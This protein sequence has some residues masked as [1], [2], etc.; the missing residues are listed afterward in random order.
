MSKLLSRSLSLRS[1]SSSKRLNQKAEQAATSTATTAARVLRDIEFTTT[2]N[3]STLANSL[4][5]TSQE[6]HDRPQTSDGVTERSMDYSYYGPYDLT[7]CEPDAFGCPAPS[8]KSILYTAE[9][10][11]DPTIGVALGSPSQAPTWFQPMGDSGR[12]LEE[13]DPYLAPA[14]HTAAH[15]NSRPRINR[16]RSLGGLFGR[17]PSKLSQ[18][19]PFYQLDQYNSQTAA[20]SY[21]D[22]YAGSA[23]AV[24]S[25]AT[26]RP[27]EADARGFRNRLGSVRRKQG[28]SQ[29]RPRTKR[30]V[31][32]PETS[33]SAM[34]LE[35]TDRGPRVPP[36]DF[37]PRR[38]S[39]LVPYTSLGNSEPNISHT[40]GGPK[41]DVEIPS[42]KM[43][44]Y[45]VM[46]GSLLKPNRTSALFARRR[47][48][49]SKLTPLQTQSLEVSTIL[50][51]PEHR[52]FS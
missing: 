17:R 36:K 38:Q 29:T 3:V 35:R 39:S 14:A 51:Q 24:H 4:P 8:P 23:D 22:S 21:A 18:K 50:D 1:R 46:F 33:R 45:S 49:A 41:L 25:V 12:A 31:T 30:S 20:T 28:A 5:H 47:S 9:V 7:S 19:A 42:V 27:A 26:S 43:E 10:H 40:G 11:I 48:N 32:E 2:V 44:R 16:W 37:P 6:D 15:K 13:T 52:W 34:S